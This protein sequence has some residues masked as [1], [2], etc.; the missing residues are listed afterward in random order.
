[1]NFK[2][3]P[4]IPNAKN[5]TPV[6]LATKLGKTHF[7][8]QLTAAKADLNFLTKSGTNPLILSVQNKNQ[9]VKIIYLLKLNKIFRLSS[10]F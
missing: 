1:L 5:E 4:N 2:A 8:S 10:F 7:L 9:D 3:D 6:F